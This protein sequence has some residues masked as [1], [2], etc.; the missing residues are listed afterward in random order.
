MNSLIEK[1][2]IRPHEGFFSPNDSDRK[3][4]SYK[5]CFLGIDDLQDI[6]NLQNLIARNLP[7]AEVFRL[8]EEDYFR[9]LF[10]LERSVVGVVTEQGL[11][12]YSIIRIPGNGEDNLGRDIGFSQSELRKVAH[13][14]AVVVHPFFRGNGLQQKMA[15]AHLQVIEDLGL[16]H[17]CC[18]VSPKNPVSLENIFSSGFVI[19]G[20]RPKFQEWWRYI[21]YK[22]ILDKLNLDKSKASKE[23][24]IIDSDLKG[25]AD[26]LKMGFVGFKMDHLP[27]GYRI[28]YTKP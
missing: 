14:Q 16:L 1:G 6:L 26:I 8:H 15:K 4:V 20:L 28:Y 24:S 22:N 19:K 7:L 12:A 13:L 3:R 21:M 17:V 10:I 18:T 2:K 23:V 5:M 27:E 25:Q 9:D 11:I